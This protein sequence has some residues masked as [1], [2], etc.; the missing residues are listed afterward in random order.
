M[1]GVSVQKGEGDFDLV[2]PG[3]G[4]VRMLRVSQSFA[5]RRRR[6]KVQSRVF[7]GHAPRKTLHSGEMG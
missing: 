7:R 1:G 4:G 6:N 2:Y 3:G 5:V